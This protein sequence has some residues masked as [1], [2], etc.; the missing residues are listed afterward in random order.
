MR[1]CRQ[2]SEGLGVLRA[3]AG[4]LP[5]FVVVGL[6]TNW[7]VTLDQIRQALRIVGRERVLGLVTPREVGGVRE[8]R[9]GGDARGRQALA[10]PRARG[11]LGRAQRR[12]QRLVLQ[13]RPPPD[14]QGRARDRAADPG[15]LTAEPAPPE[16]EPPA[17][18]PPG[19]GVPAPSAVSAGS[20]PGAASG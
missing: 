16:P 18:P 3:R 6:G 20:V 4:S 2:M 19:G 7:T 15:A 10:E 5:R 17:G 1:G 12:P 11:R 8:L 14:A 9:P 13:R